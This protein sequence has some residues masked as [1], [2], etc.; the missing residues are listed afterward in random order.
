MSSSI[1]L[2][3]FSWDRASHKTKSFLS[4]PGR[5]L[6]YA[7][8]C[9]VIMDLELRAACPQLHVEAGIQTKVLMLSEQEHLPTGS[10]TQPSLLSLMPL[11][12]SA[13]M[14]A[15]LEVRNLSS[16]LYLSKMPLFVL[17]LFY[18]LSTPCA[19][20]SCLKMNCFFI[21][22]IFSES[23]TIVRKFPLVEPYFHWDDIFFLLWMPFW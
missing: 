5:L 16:I 2:T 9:P 11:S 18:F 19:W 15:F 10:S 20:Y 14:R 3:L 17:L 4:G 13:G 7:C 22:F 23:G 12:L 8:P 21:E 6:G 1:A